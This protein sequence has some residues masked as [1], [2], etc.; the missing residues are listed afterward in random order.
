[1]AKGLPA[2]ERS[3]VL[4]TVKGTVDLLIE[5]QAEKTSVKHSEE[6]R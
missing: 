1:M 6:F 3:A 4:R 5:H 2:P